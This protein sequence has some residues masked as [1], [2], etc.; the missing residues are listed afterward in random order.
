[1]TWRS[2]VAALSAAATLTALGGCGHVESHVAMLR[3]AAKPLRNGK[4]VELYLVNQ[5]QPSRPFMDLAIVQAVGFGA[6]ATPEA[7][8]RALSD[9]AATLGCEA[10]VRVSID[11][12]YTRAHAAGICVRFLD[13]AASTPRDDAPILPAAPERNPPPP[14]M[15]PAPTPRLEPLPSSSRQ[16]R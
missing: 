5:A 3:P 8:V 9:K 1:M 2:A 16:G 7:V 12:G 15:R 4:D 11:L 14:P 10:V 13:G 6:D